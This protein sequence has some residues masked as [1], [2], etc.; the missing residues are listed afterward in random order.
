MFNLRVLGL[1]FGALGALG[2]GAF[3][4]GAMAQP[5]TPSVDH[6]NRFAVTN[7]DVARRFVQ[8]ASTRRVDIAIIGDSNT[9][10]NLVSGHEDGFG[11]AFAARFGAYATRVDAVAGQGPW[12]ATLNGAASYQ[13][14]PFV[15]AE[16]APY[17]VSKFVMTDPQMP[18][19]GAWLAPGVELTVDMNGGLILLPENPI[20]IDGPLR[21][22][23]SDVALGTGVGGFISLSVR[24]PWPGTLSSQFASAPSSWSSAG[25]I[26]AMRSRSFDIAPGARGAGVLITPVDPANG[27]FAVGPFAPTWH[28]VERTDRLTGI[29]YS[30]LWYGGGLSA[31][32]VCASFSN[33]ASV[34]PAVTQYLTEL[35]R[36]QNASPVLM[37]HILH[38]GNDANF[39]WSSLGPTGPF[40]SDTR[41]GHRDNILCI[42]ERL[43]AMWA[44]MRRP[45]ENLFFL[46]GPYHPRAVDQEFQQAFEAAWR[47]VAEGDPQVIVIGGSMLST[48]GEFQSRGF[49]AAANDLAHLS[50]PGYRTWGQVGVDAMLWAV[51]PADVN[52]DRAVTT[53]DIFTFINA[54]FM[55]EPVGDFDYSGQPGVNDIVDFLN[56][57]FAGC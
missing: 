20:G 47:D 18:R 24:Q 21:Y 56:A 49:F 33:L 53:A 1:R 9:R 22:H 19:A 36:Q 2:V 46:L 12:A 38:G 51:C 14:S 26:G 41:E 28:R 3:G 37:V 54:W 40:A 15:G 13:I 11:R 48:P 4:A 43:R 42:L 7:V 25:P 50:V 10:S 32:H 17:W 44:E 29:S 27:R 8:L 34:D 57:W 5:V 6:P 45:P 30:P 31:F 16:N 23:L 39:S 35:T 55:R 52:L